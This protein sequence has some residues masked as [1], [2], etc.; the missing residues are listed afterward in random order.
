MRFFLFPEVRLYCYQLQKT[1]Q[2]WQVAL[3][4]RSLLFP[5]GSWC[6][7]D[8]V[9]TLQ[10]WSF[11]FPQSCGI[12][13][14]IPHWPSKPNSLGAHFLGRHPFFHKTVKWILTVGNCNR[15]EPNLTT[16]WICFSF[17]LTFASCCFYSL[18]G[19]CL[20]TMACLRE[21]CPSA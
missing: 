17:T 7:Q 2:Y 6:A 4:H 14:I 16:C 12:P 18:K 8:L 15:E 20:C 10:E 11:C 5:P 9:C 21:H 1:F 13:V 3:A 19:Y